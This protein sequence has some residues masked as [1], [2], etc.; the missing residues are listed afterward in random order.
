MSLFL[1]FGKI[2]LAIGKI[3]NYKNNTYTHNKV[4]LKKNTL[5]NHIANHTKEKKN[6]TNHHSLLDESN[7]SGLS[8]WSNSFNFAKSANSRVDPRTG[9]LLIS[10]KVGLLQSNFGHGPDIDLEMNYNSG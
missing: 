9:M 5:N 3:K 10:M 7:S 6:K 4:S 2:N 8:I 1:Y